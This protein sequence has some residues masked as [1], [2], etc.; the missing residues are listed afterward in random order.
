MLT[1]LD[2]S[3]EG[4]FVGAKSYGKSRLTAGFACPGYGPC[5][6]VGDPREGHAMRR[7]ES[8]ERFRALHV[9]GQ[10]VVMPTPWELGSAKKILT[11]T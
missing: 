11:R 9:P 4:K 8:T 5:D 6:T 3:A 10:P 1:S 7:N 2:Q